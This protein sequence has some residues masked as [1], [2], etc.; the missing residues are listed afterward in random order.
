MPKTRSV[1]K[2]EALENESKAVSVVRPV[3]SKPSYRPLLPPGMVLDPNGDRL[4]LDIIRECEFVPAVPVLCANPQNEVDQAVDDIISRE[5]DF[6]VLTCQMIQQQLHL[7]FTDEIMEQ[8]ASRLEGYIRDGL[9]VT[10]W[11]SV[12]EYFRTL[13]KRKIA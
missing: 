10:V 8:H 6:H 12:P 5:G 2:A 9:S 4:L 7:K 13:K 11:S 1:T 3:C